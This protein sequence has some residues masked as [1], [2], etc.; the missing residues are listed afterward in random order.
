MT[1][2][3]HVVIFCVLVFVILLIFLSLNPFCI[4]DAG[5]VG[6]TRTFG[7]VANEPLEPGFHIINPFSKI[8]R[9]STQ[10]QKYKAILHVPSKEGMSTQLSVACLYKIDGKKAPFIYTTIGRNYFEKTIEPELR[11]VVRDVTSAYQAKALYTASRD[12]LSS[13][14]KKELENLVKQNGIIIQSLPLKSV[15]LPPTIA[16]AIETKLK[17]EQESEAMKYI[18][19]KER[20][21]A[22]RRKIEAEGI[23]EFQKIVT[24]GIT[25]TL[26]K[27]K[28]I[29]ATEKLAK[30]PNSKIIIIGGGKE[31]LPLILN[32]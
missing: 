9:F 2:K 8:I 28:G 20:Q 14:M 19:Q 18:L 30:S 24:Q 15:Q 22:Q 25:P 11:S 27:W 4:I 23:A 16:H 32:N 26:L 31:G 13:K 17:A 10:T 7:K 6:V 3:Q 21:E 1:L 12:E 5:T 29:E